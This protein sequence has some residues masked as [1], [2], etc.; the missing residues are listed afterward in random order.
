MHGKDGIVSFVAAQ[1]CSLSHVFL[2]VCSYSIVPK[3]TNGCHLLKIH[4]PDND[5]LL[6]TDNPTHVMLMWISILKACRTVL[7]ELWDSTVLKI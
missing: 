6:S 7:T 3:L 5:L 1:K 2:L 4:R